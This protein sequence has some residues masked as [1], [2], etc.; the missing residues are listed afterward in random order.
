[1]TPATGFPFSLIICASVS[2]PADARTRTGAV[3]ETF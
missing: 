2:V 1:M 3:G